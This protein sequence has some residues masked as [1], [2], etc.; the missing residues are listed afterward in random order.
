MKA[1][2]KN[3]RAWILRFFVAVAVTLMVIS[4]TQP[5]W[6]GKFWAN[7]IV[8]IYGW[9]L[10]HNLEELVAVYVDSDVTP[11]WQVALAWTYVSASSAL[12]LGSTW[13]KKWWGSLILAI[14]GIGLIA[15]AAVAI[16]VVVSN[17]LSDFGIALEGTTILEVGTY[18]YA[19]LQTSYYL[20]YVAGSLMVV[21]AVLRII[22]IGNFSK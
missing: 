12:A 8:N 20:T 21:L 1:D 16:N 7:E 17:R 19:Q 18:I 5:W 9:G 4:F 11:N 3:L 14:T 10:R 13:I 22:I 2:I 15:Y 6:T